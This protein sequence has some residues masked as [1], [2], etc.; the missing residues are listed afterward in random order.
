MS[1]LPA[2]STGARLPKAARRRLGSVL[3]MLSK[4][5]FDGELE[6]LRF[7]LGGSS[8]AVDHYEKALS[9]VEELLA[10]GAD[11]ARLLALKGKLLLHL[12]RAGEAA[13]VLDES[14]RMSPRDRAIRRWLAQARL[15]AGPTEKGRMDLDGFA[16]SDDL[17][18]EGLSLAVRGDAASAE[19]IWKALIR[20][21]PGSVAGRALL[22]L[23]LAGRGR[24]KEGEKAVAEAVRLGR[25]APFLIGLRGL[26][27]RQSGK[28]EDGLRD[29]SEAI[30]KEP[31]PWLLSH[32]ADVLNRMGFFKEALADLG[33]LSSLAPAGP[34]P[35]MQAANILFDQGYFDA[36]L[37]SATN[38]VE[39]APAV[40]GLRL[41]RAALAAACGKPEAALQ[42]LAEVLR[43]APG[44]PSVELERLS[45]AAPLEPGAVLRQLP[46]APGSAG[47][48]AFIRGRCLAKLGRYSEASAAFS[49]A[50]AA[51]DCAERA[52]L[53]GTTCRLLAAPDPSFRPFPGL[54]LCGVGVRHPHEAT[55]DVVR[56]LAAAGTIFNNL[57]DPQAAE[58]LQL[59]PGKL[60]PVPRPLAGSDGER[61]D[62]ILSNLPSGE[63]AAFVT[64]I[65]P[66]MYRRIGFEL[67]ERTREGGAA[68]RAHG[69]VSLTELAFSLAALSGRVDGSGAWLALDIREALARPARLLRASPTVVYC[70]SRGAER[71]RLAKLLA[72]LRPSSQSCWLLAGSGERE[73]EARRTPVGRLGESLETADGACVVVIPPSNG[74]RRRK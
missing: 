54:T 38:A 73:F 36:A 32:R 37:R 1:G 62:W 22:G 24:V 7:L 52:K 2:I 47:W 43:L 31:L 5:G 40:A 13:R 30:E 39:L 12:G 27:A 6:N 69:A 48:K 11:D 57:P 56:V 67:A 29:L 9:L 18:L 17:L 64:R 59:F 34:E 60:R 16:G 53:Y 25:G 74:A 41:R 28:L 61:A 49:S 58:F 51:E 44:E 4:A 71:R 72:R 3:R 10:A 35:Y 14:L 42:D 23:S 21:K 46:D 70:V 45:V 63:P 33:R 50:E 66:F 55:V 8:L 68:F 19:R 15:A 65:H 26:L 20:R